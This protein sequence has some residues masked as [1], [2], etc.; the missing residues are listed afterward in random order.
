MLFPKI[1]NESVLQVGDKTRIGAT[2]S[3]VSKDEAALTSVRIDSGDGSG[4][5]DVFG[6]SYRDWYLDYEYATDGT[7]TVT[8]E[9]DNGSGPVTTSSTIQVL[10]VVDDNLFSNDD[11]LRSIKTDVL[12]WL[13]DGKSSF[14]YVHRRAQVEIMKFFDLIGKTDRTGL[15]LTKAAVVDVDEVKQWSAYLTLML[16]Y[17]DFQNSV[18]DV[19]K[20]QA[21]DFNSEMLKFRKRAYVRLDIDGDGIVDKHEGVNLLSFD[22]IRR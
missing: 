5:I 15:K 8:V 20:E 4:F 7:K 19:F 12:K 16:I 21:I 17:R 11:D 1:S 9:V 2:R 22:L 14:N 3:Y 18:D 13:P 10:S 6:A